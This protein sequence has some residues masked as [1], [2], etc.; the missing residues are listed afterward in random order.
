MNFYTSKYLELK[1]ECPLCLHVTTFILGRAHTPQTESKSKPSFG[2]L[3]HS[4]ITS[5]KHF[6]PISL[7]FEL[8]VVLLQRV[9][10]QMWWHTTAVMPE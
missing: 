2:S 6:P 9:I 8:W 4:E 5:A 3:L 1:L 7:L 10:I